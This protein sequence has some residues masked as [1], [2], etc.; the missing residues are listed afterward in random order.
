VTSNQKNSRISFL[1]D[2]V[3]ARIAEEHPRLYPGLGKEWQKV[4][5]K[6]RISAPSMDQND[7]DYFTK[8]VAAMIKEDAIVCGINESTSSSSTQDYF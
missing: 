4:G 7:E 5:G 6:I 3:Y 8:L 1:K 2:Q